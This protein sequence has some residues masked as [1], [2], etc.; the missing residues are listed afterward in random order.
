MQDPHPGT[1]AS[2]GDRLRRPPLWL[3][4]RSTGLRYRL[5]ARRAA[6]DIC[7]YRNS[8]FVVAGI[9]GVVGSPSCGVRRTLELSGPVEAMA[10]C[11]LAALDRRAFNRQVIAANAVARE[12]LVVRQLRRALDRKGIQEHELLPTMRADHPRRNE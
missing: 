3:F 9:V 5:L 12:G 4:T 7:D 11:P 2:A 10:A 6:G 8:G 1:P